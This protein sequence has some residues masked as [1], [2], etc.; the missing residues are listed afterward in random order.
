MNDL[1]I[2]LTQDIQ[3]LTTFRRRSTDFL[4]PLREKQ[5]P[6]GGAG[7][8]EKRFGKEDRISASLALITFWCDVRGLDPRGIFGSANVQSCP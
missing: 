2:D 3:S 8:G 4:K 6:V 1:T 7:F 5:A